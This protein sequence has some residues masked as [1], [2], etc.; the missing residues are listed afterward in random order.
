MLP[1]SDPTTTRVMVTAADA[2]ARDPFLNAT[3]AEVEKL[4]L[5]VERTPNGMAYAIY[6]DEKKLD[7]GDKVHVRVWLKGYAANA[8]TMPPKRLIEA[9]EHL[10]AYDRR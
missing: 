2:A 1:P 9:I 10:D 3:N 4:G 7:H 6:R 5:R 8:A